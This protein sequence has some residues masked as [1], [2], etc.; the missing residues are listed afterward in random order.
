[1][2]RDRLAGVVMRT[3]IGEQSEL[4]FVAVQ[5]ID[6]GDLDQCEGHGEGKGDRLKLYFRGRPNKT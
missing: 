6:K 4:V 5:A 2:A 1:M 3:D